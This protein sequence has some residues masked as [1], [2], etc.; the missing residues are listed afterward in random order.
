LIQIKP[1]ERR[2]SP[3]SPLM[4][5]NGWRLSLSGSASWRRLCSRCSSL[6]EGYERASCGRKDRLFLPQTGAIVPP[7]SDF[8]TFIFRCQT[9][10]AEYR[11]VCTEAPPTHDKQLTCLSCGGPLNNR[12]GKLAL[13]YFRISDGIEPGRMNGRKP[14]FQLSSQAQETGPKARHVPRGTCR[15]ASLAASF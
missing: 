15:A 14:K 6:L 2:R 4:L 9:C 12:E 3:R 1:G 7:M 8:A 5:R 10:D 13:K 11:V